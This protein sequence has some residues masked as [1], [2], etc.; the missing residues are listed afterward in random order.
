MADVPDGFACPLACI[1]AFIFEQPNQG[2]ALERG[3]RVLFTLSLGVHLFFHVYFPQRHGNGLSTMG[4]PELWGSVTQIVLWL[5]GK[6]MSHTG[7][8]RQ[9][10]HFL[11]P[12]A[13][14]PCPFLVASFIPAFMF[15]CS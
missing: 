5:R 7:A 13:S 4:V 10:F 15:S 1:G 3:V 12:E 9:L 8:R 6:G 14:L 11:P 2:V